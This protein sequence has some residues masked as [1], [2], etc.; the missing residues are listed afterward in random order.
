MRKTWLTLALLLT[1]ST[2][3]SADQYKTLLNPYTGKMDFVNVTVSSATY[4][5]TIGP[6]QYYYFDA[7]HT[8]Y[9]F[10]DGTAVY[11]YVN[12]QLLETWSYSQV[13]RYLI[14]EGNNVTLEGNKLTIRY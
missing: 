1:G 3:F 11:M 8:T 6:Q 13:S 10:Y 14:L 2:C 4:A 5:S 12:G 9:L 7:T